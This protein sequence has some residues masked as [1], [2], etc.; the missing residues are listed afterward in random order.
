MTRLL[1][2]TG[3]LFGLCAVALG[4]F[5]AHALEGR[6]SPERAEVWTTAADYLGWHG[7][8]LLALAALIGSLR[9][10]SP[11][12]RLIGISAWL[13]IAGTLI[14]SGSLFILVLSG[15]GAIGAV[16]P[17]GGL[18]LIAGWAIAAL[19]AWRLTATD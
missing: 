4:A 18:L 19:G 15:I 10:P 2:I 8:V 16:T 12:R 11:A 3:S 6:I 14:F 7:A 17:L 13:L 5:G 9:T 1:A